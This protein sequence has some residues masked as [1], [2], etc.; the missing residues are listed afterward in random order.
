MNEN[1]TKQNKKRWALTTNM[2]SSSSRATRNADRF[3][4][5]LT[6]D[7]EKGVAQRAHKGL[8]SYNK[9]FPAKL[10]WRGRAG[11][12]VAIEWCESKHSLIREWPSAW[13]CT[14]I[15]SLL[16]SAGMM[17]KTACKG[18]NLLDHER[19]LRRWSSPT[20]TALLSWQVLH[21]IS[22]TWFLS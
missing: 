5:V 3:G 17:E 13:G 19:K 14:R 12:E 16:L 6:E 18:V 15:R 20:A 21:G 2:R 7:R 11:R 10:E 8:V 4:T 22:K 1:K 9:Y